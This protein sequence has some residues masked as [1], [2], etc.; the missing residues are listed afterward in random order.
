MTDPVTSRSLSTDECVEIIAAEVIK[1]TFHGFNRVEADFIL[2]FMGEHLI[3]EVRVT[4]DE[5]LAIVADLL[6]RIEQAPLTRC[7]L[8]S[9]REVFTNLSYAAKE[10]CL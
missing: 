2:V 1:M 6:T 4:P 9:V 7:Y 5:W 10:H 3:S 8:D